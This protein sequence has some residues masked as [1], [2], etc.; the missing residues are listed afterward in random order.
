MISILLQLL[1]GEIQ[2]H[3]DQ[4]TLINR[5]ATFRRLANHLL[6]GLEGRLRSKSPRSLPFGLQLEPTVDC[7]LSCDYCPRTGVV[8][9]PEIGEMAWDDYERLM[10]EVGPYLV[11]VA[12]W[13]WGEPLLHPRIADMVRLAHD[14]GCLTLLSTNGQVGGDC[15]V[16]ALFEAGLDLLIIS[17]DGAAQDVYEQTRQGGSLQRV[18]EFAARAA[19][20]KRRRGLATPLINL[21]TV[22]TRVNKKEID[23]IRKFARDVGV[24][25]YTAKSVSLYYDGSPDS[26]VL[27]QSKELR[28]F[29]YQDQSTAESYA[30]LGNFCRKPW[31]W[32]CLRHDGQLLLC[33]CDHGLKEPLGNVFQTGSF[34]AVWAG[35]AAAAARRKFSSTGRIDLDF[36]RRCRYKLDDAIRQV[37]RFDQDGS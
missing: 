14:H 15:D 9:G 19:M 1:R 2:L 32:P 5:N 7:Q 4:F 35:G 29:Q 11:V 37:T 24:D 30:A 36:C 34:R 21:R 23:S 33:E 13:Q 25:A 16:G 22:A 3:Y 10:T 12:F 31:Y 26:P 27:P 6:R 18:K 28:S 8:A 17:M 20:E